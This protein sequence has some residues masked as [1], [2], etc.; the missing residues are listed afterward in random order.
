MFLPIQY[1]QLDPAVYDTR[2]IME[3]FELVWGLQE[4]MQ[5][6]IDTAKTATEAEIQQ[7]G[8]QALILPLQAGVRPTPL[9]LAP[10]RPRQGVRQG[11]NAGHG[12]CQLLI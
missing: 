7:G 4:A 2:I 11:A 6:S 8:T 5:G 9:C 3:K 12:L 1:Q 10:L